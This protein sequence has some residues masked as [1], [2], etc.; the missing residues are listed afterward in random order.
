LSIWIAA[1]AIQTAGF[2]PKRT[3]TSRNTIKY[4]SVSKYDIMTCRQVSLVS[5]FVCVLY[6]FKTT[7]S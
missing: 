6:N 5:D 3:T 4:L 1:A 7:R 2:N